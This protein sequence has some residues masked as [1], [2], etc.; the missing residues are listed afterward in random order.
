MTE[1]EGSLIAQDWPEALVRELE[2]NRDNGRVGHRLV[3]ETDR[4]R[5]WHMTLAPGE[6]VGFHCHV[7]D[8]FWTALSAGTSRSHYSDGTT[9]EVTYKAGDTRHLT[10]GAGERM[11]H[12]LENIG[13]TP[14][15][16]VT[17]EFKDSSNPALPV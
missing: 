1:A 6:R 17:V 3:S 12:D 16:F 7:L 14:L 13:D 11:Q 8:Y 5:V 10:F 9:R 15:Q 2:E 4:L